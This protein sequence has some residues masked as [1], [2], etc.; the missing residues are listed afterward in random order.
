VDTWIRPA[1]GRCGP[2]NGEKVDPCEFIWTGMYEPLRVCTR[3][4]PGDS[5]IYLYIHSKTEICPGAFEPGQSVNLKI[6]GE[7]VTNPAARECMAIQVQ[8]AY[9]FASCLPLWTR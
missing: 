5:R 3:C 7:L 9:R 6:N 8:P 4:P 2:L 1:I